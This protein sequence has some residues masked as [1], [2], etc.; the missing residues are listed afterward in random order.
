[1]S[2]QKNELLY[3]RFGINYNEIDISFRKG[4]LLVWGEIEV[5]IRGQSAEEG[6]AVRTRTKKRVLLVHDDVIKD[7]WWETG[8]GKGILD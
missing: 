4:N 3:S 5:P 1:M 6:A 7:E 8:R 2:S